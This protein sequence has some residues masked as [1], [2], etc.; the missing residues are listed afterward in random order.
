MNLGYTEVC[1]VVLSIYVVVTI[2]FSLRGMKQTSTM[3][4]YALGKGFS[5]WIVALSLAASITSAATFII[6]PGF[7]AMYGWS[8]FLAMS[9]MLPLGLYISL[10]VLSKSFR[11]MGLQSESLTLSQWVGKRFDSK[12]FSIYM[13]CLSL[14]LITFIVLICV[15]LTKV[16]ANA[17][18]A[19]ETWVLICTVLFVF[20]Y[21]MVGGANTMVYTNMIQ[22]ILMIIVA[23]MVLYSG[24]E[25]FEQ[26][27]SGFWSKVN[28]LDPNM[29]TSFNP[30]SPLFRDAFE[31]MFCNFIVGIAVVC[32]PHIITRSLMLKSDKDV[33]KYLLI[34]IVVESIFFAVLFAGFYARFEFPEMK[35]GDT[36]LKI[37]SVFSA[38]VIKEF[39]VYTGIIVIMG[40]I[41]AGISTLEGLIQSLSSTITNDLI[42][43]FSKKERSSKQISNINKIVIAILGIIAILVSLYQLKNPNLSVGILA[44]NGVYAFFSAAFVT[45]LFGIFVKT[46]KKQ[47]VI[48]ASVTAI[49]VHFS[50]YYLN[51]S[52]YTSSVVKNPAVAATYA[53]L[54]SVAIA[55]ILQIFL[56]SPSKK[57]KV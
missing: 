17:L 27:I 42:L 7:V 52:Y 24:R 12:A 57:H 48:I 43:V 47:A 32:Q 4:D 54:S 5:P 50:V 6:N 30:I 35:N 14:L 34:A 31:V 38:Y 8:A 40:L 49:L 11:A 46:A 36:V 29:A 51:L 20:G 39:S 16:L 56:P 22:A 21:M 41:A 18:S 19:P 1:I 45:V 23:L 55:I 15:G 37:D 28:A 53:I 9:V 2:Y 33:N 3:K 26:G 10:V 25:H 44:Q 13:A